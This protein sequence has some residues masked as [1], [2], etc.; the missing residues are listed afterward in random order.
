MNK[1]Y[2]EKVKP[3]LKPNVKLMPHL[4]AKID[5]IG[6]VNRLTYK[7]CKGSHTPK[8]LTQLGV[9]ITQLI[10]L[11]Q[12]GYVHGDIRI[13][14]L[15]YSY[16]GKEAYILDYDFANIEGEFYPEEFYIWKAHCR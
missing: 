14:N 6:R 7:Y 16:D 13:E 3:F 10:N 8:S 2:D 1:L 5:Q 9:L 15:L 12:Q 4:N 11:H